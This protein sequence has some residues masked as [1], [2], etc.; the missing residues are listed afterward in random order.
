MRFLYL[1]SSAWVKRY[2]HERGSE[3]VHE[4]ISGEGPRACSV[5]GMVEVI[6]TLARKRKAGE[7]TKQ[8]FDLKVAET[9]RDWRKFF[10]IELTL[11]MVGWAKEAAV[12]LALRGADAVHFAALLSLQM[13]V[14]GSGHHVV[15]VASDRELKDA[16]ASSGI[17]VLDPEIESAAPYP[18]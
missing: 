1:D 13:H 3:C 9:V 4:L 16:A 6:A 2:Q 11:E 8:D 15:L 14:S 7:I 12:R 17:K 18:T 10:Q 5:L